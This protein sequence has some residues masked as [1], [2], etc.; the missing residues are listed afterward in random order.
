[1]T[2]PCFDTQAPDTAGAQPHPWEATFGIS[3]SLGVLHEWFSALGSCFHGFFQHIPA[4]EALIPFADKP[5]GR[6]LTS[7]AISLNDVHPHSEYPQDLKGQKCLS[8][9]SQKRQT[10]LSVIQIYQP[11]PF[12]PR[13]TYTLTLLTYTLIYS[14]CTY[15][16]ALNTPPTH[17]LELS[18]PCPRNL[19]SELHW[20]TYVTLHASQVCDMPC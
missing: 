18:R 1:M 8:I 14:I 3:F 10:L 2:N 5:F 15:T 12:T 11:W 4:Y 20:D 6:R 19:Y 16:H 17:M 7:L 9:E 13:L